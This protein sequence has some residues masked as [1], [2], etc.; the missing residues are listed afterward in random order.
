MRATLT[1]TLVIASVAAGL[2]GIG[3]GCETIEENPRTSGTLIGA[4]AGAGIGSVVAG[5]GNKTE[6]ALVGAGVG[7]AGGWLAGNAA[8]EAGKKKDREERDRARDDYND[9]YERAREADYRER[10]DRYDDFD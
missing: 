5:K 10:N 1:S 8:D 7:A 9:S 4:G 6:G 2:A 3:G